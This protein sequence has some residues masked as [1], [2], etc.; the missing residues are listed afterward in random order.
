MLHDHIERIFP[1][2]SVL[3]RDPGSTPV[4]EKIRDI[5]KS[6]SED[7]PISRDTELLLFAAARAQL[8]QRIQS[9]MLQDKM[10]ICD[11]FVWS[12]WAYQHY[13]RN[14]AA[15]DVISTLYIA[16][17]D[18][19]ADVLLWLKLS[20][21]ELESRKSKR[22]LPDKFESDPGFVD[23][24]LAGYAQIKPQTAIDIQADGSPSEVHTRII[25]SLSASPVY[26]NWVDRV[27]VNRRKEIGKSAA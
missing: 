23:R 10:V 7:D 12:T 21:E 6:A 27:L 5:V 1:Y 15:A 16:T 18:L 17:R 9:E 11:R 13:G 20:P 3:V 19:D 25:H 24:V 8:V 22:G 14:H 4:A 26:V 2:A